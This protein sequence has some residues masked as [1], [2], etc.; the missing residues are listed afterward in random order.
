MM[1]GEK[2][3]VGYFL[4]GDP[5]PGESLDLVLDAV[6][7]GVDILEIGIPSANPVR[8]G[9]I[10]RRA[11]RRAM[12]HGDPAA[13]LPEYFRRLRAGTAVPVWAMAYRRDF[14]DNG[15]YELY[16]RER[17]IDALVIP[18]MSDGELAAL[19]KRLAAESVDVVRFVNPE[20]DGRTIAAIASEARIVYAQMYA[21][22]TGNPFADPAAAGRMMDVL[23]SS[24]AMIVAGFGLNSPEKVGRV[25]A[26]GYDGAVVGSSFVSRIEFG[27][28]DSL[29]R[30]IADMKQAAKLESGG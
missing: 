18:D 27:E 17:L 26:S 1:R 5:T 10:I 11:H 22:T 14:I 20:M 19:Q 13:W 3:L 4:A 15:A 9:D 28:R 21:G 2:R 23:R 7:A 8:D 25:L 24:P 16:V 30:L 6:T 29:Y 12:K